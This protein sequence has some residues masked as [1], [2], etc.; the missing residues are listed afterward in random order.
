MDDF[1]VTCQK[2]R[3]YS[4]WCFTEK[5]CHRNKHSEA[6]FFMVTSSVL[7]GKEEIHT[8]ARPQYQGIP[9]EEKGRNR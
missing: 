3:I 4:L 1:C 8:M 5:Y 2:Y 7:G 9:N 6:V